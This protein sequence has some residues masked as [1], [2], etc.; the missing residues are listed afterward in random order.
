MSTSNAVLNEIIPKRRISS[1]WFE[2][3]CGLN[4]ILSLYFSKSSAS[5]S[6]RFFESENAVADANFTT[7]ASIKSNTPSCNTSEY[8]SISLNCD[9][10]IPFN[11]ALATEPTPDCSG[12]NDGGNLPSSTSFAKKS[13]KLLAICCVSSFGS[14][15]GEG[16]SGCSD[17]IIPFTFTGSTL[18]PAS[19]IR[20][21]ALYNGIS[22]RSPWSANT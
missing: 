14:N 19:P 21:P 16:I 7:P 3:S 11:T 20:S 5:D 4:I 2:I 15:N 17:K 9:V 1:G 6:T 8:T 13:S 12:A 22:R 10:F 18:M